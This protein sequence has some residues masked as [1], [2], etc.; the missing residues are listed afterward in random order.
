MYY[1][2]VLSCDIVLSLGEYHYGNALGSLLC[3]PLFL[4]FLVANFI[5]WLSFR[6]ARVGHQ[7]LSYHLLEWKAFPSSFRNKESKATCDLS[8][9]SN[10]YFKRKAQIPFFFV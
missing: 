9:W 5:L 1:F 2:I 7:K 3:L 8:S 10:P 6:S 4:S